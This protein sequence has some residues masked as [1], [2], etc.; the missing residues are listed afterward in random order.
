MTKVPDGGMTMLPAE[1]DFHFRETFHETP[2]P[3]SYE[4]LLLDALNGDASLFARNDEIA[5]AWKLI[6]A[7]RQGWEGEA[8][9]VLQMYEQGSWGPADADRLLWRDGRWW[10]HDGA[11]HRTEGH[12]GGR[13]G[14]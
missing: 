12:N 4:R 6:D 14:I 7:I 8:A 2:I 3:E 10:V 1:M 9:P 5:L 13:V 11:L